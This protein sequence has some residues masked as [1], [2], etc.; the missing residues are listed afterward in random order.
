MSNQ[1]FLIEV[2]C[3]PR[4]GKT[5]DNLGTNWSQLV[6]PTPTCARDLHASTVFRGSDCHPHTHTGLTSSGFHRFRRK[7]C[8][9][10]TH[11]A[12]GLTSRR[13]LLN[14]MPPTHGDYPASCLARAKSRYPTRSHTGL[15]FAS[16]AEICGIG[17]MPRRMGKF[18][19]FRTLHLK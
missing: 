18:P 4:T 13:I 12:Y 19:T 1:I 17:Q 10:R 6:P 15:T 16:S 14:V 5:K 2:R 9:P 8:H 7:P 11:R 3:L